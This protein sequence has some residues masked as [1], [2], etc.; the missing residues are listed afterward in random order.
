MQPN[1]TSFFSI[2]DYS[3]YVHLGCSPEERKYKQEVLFSVNIKFTSPP[4]GEV[5]DQLNDTICYANICSLI[6]ELT[7]TKHF[8]LVESL[9]LTL[10]SNLKKIIPD[11]FITVQCHKV[12]PPIPHLNGGVKYVCSG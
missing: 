3:C 2:E 8:Q 9:C 4:K 5:T 1:H 7:S 6:D 12:K 11:D 10:L